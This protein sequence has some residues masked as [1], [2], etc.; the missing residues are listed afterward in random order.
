MDLSTTEHA[1]RDAQPIPAVVRRPALAL[2]LF[3]RGLDYREAAALIGGCTHAAVRTWCLPFGHPE[4]RVPRVGMRA[5]IA[6]VTAG[7][8]PPDSFNPP[9]GSNSSGA[10]AP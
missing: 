5:K 8:V 9:D 3:N 1:T 10:A 7:I 6:Q 2:F 4:R